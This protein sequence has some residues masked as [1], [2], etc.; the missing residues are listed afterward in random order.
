MDFR[1]SEKEEALRREVIEFCKRELP[2]DWRGG[3]LEAADTDEAWAFSMKMSKKLAQKGWLTMA[4]PKEYGGMGA[5]IME[6]LVYREETAYWGVP[7]TGMGVGGVDWV[8]PSLMIYGTEEQKKTY[9]PMIASGEEDGVWCTGYSE[10][11]AGSDFASIQ[12]RAVREGDEYVINGQK[13]WTSEAHRS[14]WCWLAA[15]TDPDAPKHKG[16]SVFIVDMK[17]PGITVRPLINM[18][19][20]HSFNE[21][22]FDDVRIPASNLVGEE[23]RGWYQLM[24]SLSYERSG[25]GF[26]AM[27]RRTLYD[28]V[29]YARETKRDG[30]VIAKDPLIRQKLAEIAVEIEVARYLSYRVAWMQSKGLIPI[31]EASMGKVF[32]DEVNERLANVG[33]QVMGLYCQLE[34]GSK[35]A[36]LRGRIERM[37]VSVP[38]FKIAAGSDEIQKNIIAMRGLG[39]PRS[40]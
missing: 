11:G 27:A 13:V 17:S 24:V 35:W 4:W 31:H 32:G 5:S 1:F 29:E 20:I 9:L 15:R 3:L 6:Q 10:P 30:D 38:G 28:L 14:R 16:I 39:L 26:S 21:V 8:G 40:Y 18:A 36:P 2:P 12:T 25:V 19:G 22:F 33:M 34:P 37:Y 23:N 7:G